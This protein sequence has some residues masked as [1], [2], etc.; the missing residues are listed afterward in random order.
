MDEVLSK[1]TRLEDI[2]TS[3]GVGTWEWNVQTGEMRVNEAWTMML[4]YRIDEFEPL[5]IDTWQQHVHPDDLK[6]SNTIFEQHINGA[7]ERFQADLRV[8]H[9]N[10][11]W[12]Y[13]RS[14]GR[15]CSRTEEGLPEWIMGTHFDITDQKL[16]KH[17]VIT[18]QITLERAQEIGHLGYWTAKPNIEDL[19]WSNKIYAILGLDHD[20]FT[21]SVELFVSMVHPDD[22]DYFEENMKLLAAGERFDF[23]HRIIRP[24]GE[25]VW[26]HERAFQ[27]EINDSTMLIGTMQNIT[28]A[29]ETQ[30]K[31][32]QLSRV[33]DLTKLYNR[34]YLLEQLEQAHFEVKQNKTTAVLAMLDIDHFKSMNDTYGHDV[35]DEVLRQFARYLKASVRSS[36][37]V[38][39]SGGEEFVILM[40]DTSLDNAQRHMEQLLAGLREN[41]F[42]V[43]DTPLR[44]SATI[45]LTHVLP[46][47]SENSDV[48]IRADR[49]MYHGKKNGR[50]QVVVAKGSK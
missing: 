10:G 8:R 46:T 45:G 11:H 47:D 41:P 9:K 16:I 29:K 2:I 49:A 36:D 12:V 50:D 48:L 3:A 21:P 22:L 23:E 32:L 42:V 27:T 5:T 35:G 1:L 28:E 33:D 20:Q 6:K 44:V 24:S 34:R 13:V 30:A 39:R 15:L 38:A 18:Q 25:I 7:S 40:F 31:L 17:R 19:Y 37:I 26:V 43:Q 14:T 4:G